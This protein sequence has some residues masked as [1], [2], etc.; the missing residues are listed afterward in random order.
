M[1]IAATAPAVNTENWKPVVG[2]EGLYEVSSHGRVKSM[3]SGHGRFAGRILKPHVHTSGYPDVKLFAEGRRRHMLIHRLVLT[4][5]V[6]PRPKGMECRHLDG[7][8]TNNHISNI[9]WGT[10]SEN[11]GDKF[12]HGTVARGERHGEAK[13]T[14]SKVREIRKLLCQ[15]VVQTKI[16]RL[17]GV[18]R[19]AIM[20]IKSGKRWRHV[21]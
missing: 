5:F 8:P 3:R 21:D 11:I 14:D 17:F 1:T 7:D 15:G 2:Y 18:G 12:R 4:A 20:Y 10:R 6:G 16:G 13:L 9:C 19:T